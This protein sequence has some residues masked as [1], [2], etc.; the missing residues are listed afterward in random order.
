MASRVVVFPALLGLFVA[1]LQR[2][3]QA[4]H[5]NNL[6]F[7]SPYKDDDFL[8]MDPVRVARRALK[9]RGAARRSEDDHRHIW[10][11]TLNTHHNES[12]D[13]QTHHVYKGNLN[14]T[15][16]VASGDPYDTSVILWTRAVPA[17][18]HGDAFACVTYRVYTTEDLSG[19]PLTQG[20]AWTA[21][22]VDWTVKIEATG[23]QPESYYYYQWAN[24]A[25]PEEQSPTGRT[26]TAPSKHGKNVG[27]Q[28]FAVF[29]CADYSSGFFNAYSGPVVNDDADYVLHLG[30]YIYEH[31]WGGEDIGRAHEPYQEIT[32]LI[33]YRLRY[34]QY[35]TDQ[36][37]QALHHKYP[38]LAVWDDHETADNDWGN[39]NEG[40]SASGDFT[41]S[42]RE[43]SANAKR[44]YFEWIPIRQVDRNDRN[45]IWR[46]FAFGDLVDIIAIDTRKYDRDLTDLYWN[47]DLVSKLATEVDSN[48][49]IIGDTQRDWFLQQLSNSQQRGTRFTL[50]LNQV[51]FG[52]VDMSAA[53]YGATNLDAWDGYQADRRRVLDH[54]YDNKIDNVVFL[55]GDTHA[56][57]MLE[58]N[59]DNTLLGPKQD[60]RSPAV[61]KKSNDREA[62]RGQIV[63]FGVG[64]VTSAGWGD[65]MGS[66]AEA[67]QARGIPLVNE[68]GGLLYAEGWYKGYASVV[69]S[70]QSITTTYW[71][72]QTVRTRNQERKKLAEFV[73][74]HNRN[75]VKRPLPEVIGARKPGN[76]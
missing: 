40:G 26:K 34:A 42:Y 46:H 73:V 24:C 9:K 25:K 17:H 76:F 57:W 38:L 50:V 30:D 36:D 65:W 14:F 68:A 28:R 33:D 31:G 29:S 2:V 48:R 75:Q 32:R 66:E 69:V 53:D 54:I 55:T 74:E 11:Q 43:R 64:A 12:D 27:T 19:T 15:H 59:K 7:R 58:V 63:E 6:A 1:A 16:G 21:E 37:L 56:T 51:I 45:R 18:E 49:S 10:S 20:V 8:A 47:T 71:G 62:L 67:T 39:E 41:V 22:D 4:T 3:V 5:S 70:P 72:Y 52:S 60:A 23:L 61:A 44:A 35:R 13:E